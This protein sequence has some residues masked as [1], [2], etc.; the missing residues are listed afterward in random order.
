MKSAN[1]QPIGRIHDKWHIV[2]VLYNHRTTLE[3]D[4]FGTCEPSIGDV[5]GLAIVRLGLVS[6]RSR[7]VIG[8]RVSL[9]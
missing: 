9:D 5:F 8:V 7:S 4:I 2:P 6:G 1:R 3:G